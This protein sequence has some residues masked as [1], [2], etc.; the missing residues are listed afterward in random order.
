MTV[1]ERAGK[2]A[3]AATL[4]DVERLVKAYYEEQPDPGDAAQQVAFGTRGTPPS[5]WPS[6][7]RGIGG[8]P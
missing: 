1:N 3:E 4:V 7:P 2:P 6:G 5:R 8:R